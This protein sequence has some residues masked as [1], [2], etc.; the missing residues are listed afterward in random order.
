[1]SFTNFLFISFFLILN[2]SETN[3]KSQFQLNIPKTKEDIELNNRKN[4]SP[5]TDLI[6]KNILSTYKLLGDSSF[7]LYNFCQ[8]NYEMLGANTEIIKKN[9]P[10]C[11]SFI[12]RYFCTYYY[13]NN[14][15][16][17]CENKSINSILQK[18][19]SKEIKTNI[20][21][22]ENYCKSNFDIENLKECYEII[23]KFNNCITSKNLLYNID[24][25][26]DDKNIFD[27]CYN[28]KYPIYDC[29]FS[30][31]YYNNEFQKNLCS[32]YILPTVA[33]MTIN[34]ENNYM[35]ID[36][37]EYCQN[38]GDKMKIILEQ[39]EDHILKQEKQFDD[40]KSIMKNILIFSQEEIF[41]KSNQ[42]L[43]LISLFNMKLQNITNVNEIFLN[44]NKT[45]NFLDELM[46][47]IDDQ[48][49]EDD[50]SDKKLPLFKQFYGKLFENLKNL[51]DEISEKNEGNVTQIN[52]IIDKSKKFLKYIY[53]QVLRIKEQIEDNFIKIKEYEEKVENIIM[54]IDK[55][56]KD[57]SLIIGK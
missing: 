38:Y 43:D 55:Q 40:Q 29:S 42:I 35:K 36:E 32:N 57:Y 7:N 49:N 52:N 18:L 54:N 12:N 26:K 39:Y 33:G 22:I 10:Y 8:N 30:L 14:H 48:R 15:N 23:N 11:F 34:K 17:N 3:L 53:S 5:K 6:C 45:L 31:N 4:N 16:K 37:N 2:S 19:K 21:N 9:N 1:M 51:Y 50:L 25:E 24:P 13:S 47:Y 41:D 44:I 56:I 46:H 20:E 27:E 28:S